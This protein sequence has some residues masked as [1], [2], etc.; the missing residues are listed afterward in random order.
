LFQRI[1]QITDGMKLIMVSEKCFLGYSEE[2]PWVEDFVSACK[3][4]LGESP[5]NLDIRSTGNSPV[6]DV[7]TREAFIELIRHAPY[8][9]YDISY[10]KDKNGNWH[11]PG[12]VFI[13]LGIAIAANQK[14]LCVRN[15]KHQNYPWPDILQGIDRPIIEFSGF[16][17]LQDAL[18]RH[19]REIYFSS[20]DNYSDQQCNFINKISE[21]RAKHPRVFYTEQSRIVTV[22][23]D[24]NDNIEDFRH[25]VDQE[26]SIQQKLQFSYF[27]NAGE[28][29]T[30][31]FRF[32]SFC[33]SI[34]SSYIHIFRI[35][36]STTAEAYVALGMSLALEK[37]FPYGLPRLIFSDTED[38]QPSLLN[39]YGI[40]SA[41]NKGKKDYLRRFCAEAIKTIKSKSVRPD[42][43][44]FIDEEKTAYPEEASLVELLLDAL[45]R[46]KE[47]FSEHYFGQGAK[48]KVSDVANHL[49]SFLQGSLGSIKAKEVKISKVNHNYPLTFDILSSNE[50]CTLRVLFAW[51]EERSSLSSEYPDECVLLFK[52]TS[53]KY[54][55]QDVDAG[56]IVEISVQASEKE[57]EGE[58]EEADEADEA[59]GDEK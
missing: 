41:S 34:R 36:D 29:Y 40:R 39:G 24:D 18:Q 7:T 14:F 42:F 50:H 26:L 57:E 1:W 38:R 37:E 8:G 11:I 32:C 33:K 3:E 54:S 4:V 44:E 45:T 47:N 5:Y 49:M 22:I 15:Q 17:T 55:L 20:R 27:E 35:T 56:L 10:Q 2:S 52:Q 16:R 58:E 9:I 46:Y 48:V 13:E 21:Y 30:D 53:S 28:K 43:F 25:L 19:F 23:V 6:M 31:S 12:N 51:L 59:E